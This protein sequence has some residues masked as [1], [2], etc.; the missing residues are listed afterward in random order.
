MS[1]HAVTTYDL[2]GHIESFHHGIFA[3]LWGLFAGL[4]SAPFQLFFVSDKWARRA[5]TFGFLFGTVL[6]ALYVLRDILVAVLVFFD[7]I[8][9]GVTN[10]CFRKDLDYVLDPSWKAQVHQTPLLASE[11]EASLTQGIPKARKADLVAALDCVV[12]AR[13]VFENAHPHLPKDHRHYVVVG[14]PSLIE[15]IGTDDSKIKLGLHD[16]DVDLICDRLKMIPDR[17]LDEYQQSSRR[18]VAD[19]MGASRILQ[20]I[21][22]ES[23]LS[24]A[25]SDVKS[26]QAEAFKSYQARLTAIV[27]KLAPSYHLQGSPEEAE[28]SFSLF[29]QAL[30]PVCGRRILHSVPVPAFFSPA[31]SVHLSPLNEMKDEGDFSEYLT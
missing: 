19:K 31:S 10:G 18:L 15:V 2:A 25:E 8:I 21:Q 28:V 9:I 26:A 16:H 11:L 5:G 24:E 22:D 13:K 17:S 30:Q 1:R 4:I 29:L 20:R 7:R 14:L 12:A 3:A 6:A 23:L 27:Q